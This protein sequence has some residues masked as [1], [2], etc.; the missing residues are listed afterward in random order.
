VE[1]RELS[2][3][4]DL[5]VVDRGAGPAVVFVHGQPGLGSDFDPV[6][7][8]LVEDHRVIAADRPGYGGSGRQAC[9]MAQ[10][11]EALAVLIEERAAAPAT[12]VGHSYGGGI[13][14][15][16]AAMR[17]DLVSALV[18][19]GS[20]GTA[21]GL[22]V[23]DHLLAAPVVG[24]AMSAAGLSLVGRVL[25]RIRFLGTVFL[26][27]ELQPLVV[28]LP[29]SRYRDVVSKWGREVWRSFTF[30]QRSLL[31]E[32]ADIE[33][34]LPM[35]GV[36][37]TV[38]AGAWDVVV[39]PSVARSIARSVPGAELVILEKVGHFVLRDAPDAVAA[40]VGKTQMFVAGPTVEDREAEGGKKR[41]HKRRREQPQHRQD[42]R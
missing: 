32:I 23:I 11:A 42:S 8:L 33:A 25:P 30:E 2:A 31:R 3:V 28:T 41:R 17:P 6:A 18:L 36:P 34:S 1:R 26:R 16:L 27:D 35:V 19:V 24:E 29:D 12:V 7:T 4:P 15:L 5:S 14:V 38:I 37:T 22:N 10:N 20:V 9:S 39:P 21:D 13:A 40:A